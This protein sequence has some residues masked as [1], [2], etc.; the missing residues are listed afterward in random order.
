MNLFQAILICILYTVFT[1]AVVWF[2]LMQRT[3]LP[4]VYWSVSKN[5]CAYI[6]K[7]NVLCNCDELKQ[8]KKYEKVWVE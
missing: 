6:I 1:S 3:T 8:I 7:D 2:G 4:V 5:K